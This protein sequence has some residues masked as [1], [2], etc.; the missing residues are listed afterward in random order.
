MSTAQFVHDQVGG[1][2]CH[3]S[4]VGDLVEEHR[5]PD[6]QKWDQQEPDPGDALAL[7]LFLIREAEV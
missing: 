2:D 5:D 4:P 3:R 6:D 7:G 1:V